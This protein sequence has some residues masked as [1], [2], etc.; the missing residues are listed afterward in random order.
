MSIVSSSSVMSGGVDSSSL[1]IVDRGRAVNSVSV[2]ARLADSLE[3]LILVIELL[4]FL[5][6]EELLFILLCCIVKA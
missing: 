3:V 6:V 4:G 5:K 2:V 1:V